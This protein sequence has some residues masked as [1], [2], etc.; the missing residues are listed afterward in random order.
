MGDR[1][2][3]IVSENASVFQSDHY[4]LCYLDQKTNKLVLRRF[5]DIA[6]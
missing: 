5:T 6:Q 3:G 4:Y 2:D 1:E